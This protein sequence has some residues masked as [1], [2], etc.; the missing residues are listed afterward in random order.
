VKALLNHAQMLFKQARTRVGTGDLNRMLRAALEKNPPPLFRNS[1]PKIYYATQVGTE[2]P[3][4]VLICNNP[5]ALTN[6]YQRYLLGV[7]R[8]RLPYGEV[9]IK[10]YL[11]TRKQSD[12]LPDAEELEAGVIDNQLAGDPFDPGDE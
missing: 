12:A 2:P 11:R 1:R 10:L 8:D 5:R 9:P 6:N 7:M 4:I 3:T